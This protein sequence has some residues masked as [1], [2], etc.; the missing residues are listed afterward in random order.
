M[1]TVMEV[2]LSKEYVWGPS[3]FG[4]VL[5][6]SSPWLLR[7]AN[8]RF[9]LTVDNESV[10]IGGSGRDQMGLSHGSGR[11]EAG[12]ACPMAAHAA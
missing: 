12:W 10:A 4:R 11:Q 5:T 3:F 6:G 1:T 8:G 7:L 2:V 9:H